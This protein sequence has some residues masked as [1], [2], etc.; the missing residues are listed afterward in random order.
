MFR[1]R[2]ITS[3]L[4]IVSL[5]FTMV[6]CGDA[7]KNEQVT[8]GSSVEVAEE[9]EAP[10]ASPIP[11]PEMMSVNNLEPVKLEDKYRSCYEIFVYSF[12][13]TD[14]DGIGD[15]AGVNEKLDYIAG[16][17]FDAIWLMPIHPS[18]SYH[19]YDVTDYED[20]DPVYGNMQDF[21]DLVVRSHELGINI[22]M[23][24][25]LNHTSSEHPWFTS[26]LDYIRS[27]KDDEE[28]DPSVCPYVE[29]YNFTKEFS[30]GYTQVTDAQSEWYYESQFVD[31]MPDL[32]L[33]SEAVRGE[34]EEIIDFWLGRGVDGFRL[35][36]TTYYDSSSPQGNIEIL[37]WISDY[38]Y[39][40]NPDAYIVGEAFTN[41]ETYAPMYEGGIDSFF[42]FRFGNQNGVLINTVS[43]KTDA[44]SF[45]K[46]L[47]TMDQAISV[48][49]NDYIDA[50]FLTNHDTGRA[51]GF[52]SGD[53]APARIKMAWTLNMLQGGT[54]FMY[55]G[56]E[57][58]MKGAG[59]D[60]N[61]RVGM[62][63]SDDPQAEGMCAGPEGADIVK[64][65]YPSLEGQI[66][67]P[68]SIYNYI[69]QLM[70]IKNAYPAIARGE[71][72]FIESI[73]NASVCLI[74]K[75]YAGDSASDDNDLLLVFNISDSQQSVDISTLKLGLKSGNALEIGGMLQTDDMAPSCSAGQIDLPPYS[76]LVLK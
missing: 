70:K 17:G 66:D 46:A 48:Y 67:D 18:P 21:E 37:K 23:D 4:L 13:D 75:Y 59:K 39:S 61:K 19:K 64:M 56:E 65:M 20:I 47:T 73:S 15:L 62:L 16:L 51:A 43:G 24:L 76:T 27:L 38:V 57:L 53:G 28:P 63:W 41:L 40:V 29:Y 72:I 7:D 11:E 52:L 71:N 8:S 22:Y 10:T 58:G 14:G 74:E 49:K 30:S 25:V 32:N 35:D 68:Y 54:S 45:G 33:Y 60:E 44:S 55:Y 1:S 42:D 9:T 2:K 50:P 6:G 34:F 26:A 5:I 36:A 31:T 3:V 69:V 12:Y